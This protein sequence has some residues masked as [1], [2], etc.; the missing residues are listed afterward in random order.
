[1]IL[2]VLQ[3][4]FLHNIKLHCYTVFLLHKHILKNLQYLIPFHDASIFKLFSNVNT[5]YTFY[6]IIKML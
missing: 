3:R 2:Y 4:T 6:N 5:A 1:M